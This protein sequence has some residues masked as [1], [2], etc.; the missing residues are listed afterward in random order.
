MKPTCRAEL[1]RFPR[2]LNGEGWPFE[3]NEKGVFHIAETT[4]RDGEAVQ[5]YRFLST[6]LHVEAV[7]QSGDGTGWGRLVCVLNALGQ[8]RRVVLSAADISE[9][10]RGGVFKALADRGATI[11]TNRAL[12]EKLLDYLM[13]A[14]P[15][16]RLIV[17]DR[18]GWHE[19]TGAFVLP[20]ASFG[21]DPSA[22]VIYAPQGGAGESHPYRV[23]GT[24]KDWKARV[25]EPCRG[26]S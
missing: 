20:D 4:N 21:G 2:L 14:R 22:P 24:L 5:E 10:A 6:P 25:A 8:N 7:T 3:V 11:K 16:R 13:E 18:V 15:D 9:G 26:N 12:R 23:K 19:E 1:F 17:A